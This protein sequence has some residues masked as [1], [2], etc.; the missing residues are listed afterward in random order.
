MCIFFFIEA[1]GHMRVFGSALFGRRVSWCLVVYEIRN[2][3]P[4]GNILE[5]LV[6]K[7]SFYGECDS[8]TVPV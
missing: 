5:K 2:F 6:R 1:V 4:L 3:N 8:T 7:W